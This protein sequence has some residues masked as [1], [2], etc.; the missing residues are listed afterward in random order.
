V[1]GFGLGLAMATAL[2]TATLGVRPD[3]AGLASAT[4]NTMQQI[5]GSIGTA[6]LSTLAASATSSFATWQATATHAMAQAAVHSYTTAFWWSAAIFV[7]GAIVCGV[8]M[9]PGMPQGSVIGGRPLR[10]RISPHAP[11]ACGAT[12]GAPAAH[13]A[14]G[15]GGGKVNPR[16]RGLS[17]WCS[18]GPPGTPAYLTER[19]SSSRSRTDSRSPS[20]PPRRQRGGVAL[21]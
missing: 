4:V 14:P 3:D 17:R 18:E 9:R 1:I 19:P 5:G 2:G 13:G 7:A 21:C 11:R 8:L 6:L 20:L 12:A 10:L 15:A 16:T